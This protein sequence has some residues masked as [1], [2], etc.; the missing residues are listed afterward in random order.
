MADEIV[1]ARRGLALYLALV[2][3]ASGAVEWLLLRTGEPIGAHRGLVFL[4]MW[5][6]AL[7]SLATR[8]VMREGIRDVSFRPGSKA[9]LKAVLIAWAFPVAVGTLAYGAAWLSGLAQFSPPGLPGLRLEEASPATRFLCLLGLSAS[10][11]TLLSAAFAAGEE[12]GWRGYMLTRLIE[13]RVPRP[14]LASGLIWG[15]WHAPLILS[16][17]Y[18]SGPHPL[19]STCIFLVDVVAFAYLTAWLRLRSGSVWPAV[20]AHAAWNA[21][22]QEVFDAS[23]AGVSIWLGESG[24]IV[25]GVSLVL[26]VM[27]VRARW[28]IKRTPAEPAFAE[29]DP[30]QA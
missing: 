8:A 5:T 6:P 30:F 9:G 21:I 24:L 26:V 1:Q 3:G 20:V 28:S 29:L 2:V 23:T 7:A 25:S 16:G 12:I 19:L 11:G 22:I 13:A 14:I 10:V 17:Q 15:L 4:L 18:A 27:L